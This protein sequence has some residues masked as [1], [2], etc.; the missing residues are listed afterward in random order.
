[1]DA[2]RQMMGVR[3]LAST[4]GLT[5]ARFRTSLNA[6]AF[7]MVGLLAVAC[8]T[9]TVPAPTGGSAEPSGHAPTTEPSRLTPRP[10]PSATARPSVGNGEAWV[11]FQSL[12]DQ[13]DPSADQD[14]IDHD[15]T[16]FLV[17]TD[18]SGLHRLP[19]ETMVGSEIRPTCCL[20]YTSPSPR[21]S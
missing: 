10:T 5:G 1:M 21:D 20:L 15:D 6:I 11:V 2:G 9:G 13:F 12:A 7:A 3:Q 14:G 8:G 4:L 18:G 16:L 17:R 19:P